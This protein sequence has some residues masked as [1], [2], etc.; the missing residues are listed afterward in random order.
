VIVQVKAFQNPSET[1]PI[2][3]EKPG[4]VAGLQNEGFHAWIFTPKTDEIDTGVLRFDDDQ[5][6]CGPSA[7]GRPGPRLPHPAE[8][9]A[10]HSACFGPSRPPGP[11]RAQPGRDLIAVTP[12]PARGNR[13]GDPGD[14]A[15]G[16]LQS[17][18]IIGGHGE[19][20]G[21]GGGRR[22]EHHGVGPFENRRSP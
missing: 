9:F 21:S 13:G 5:V 19:P 8:W 12:T 2:G 22:F 17:P 6:D 10:Q 4:A 18:G 11:S 20:M 16:L 3:I 15:D 1:H 7:T 14:G